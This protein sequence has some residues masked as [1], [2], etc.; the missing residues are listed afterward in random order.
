MSSVEHA[1]V[2]TSVLDEFCGR[3]HRELG[4]EV[5]DP[6]KAEMGRFLRS[7]D[8]DLEAAFALYRQHVEWRT[9][10]R[11]SEL[12]PE[13]MPTFFASGMSRVAGHDKAGHPILLMK[14]G[15]YQ[16]R[17][18]TPVRIPPALRRLCS[19]YTRLPLPLPPP[20][21]TG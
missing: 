1:A 18:T 5:T 13:R 17:I 20:S 12:T 21:R 16:P 15:R 7:R 2:D 8:N 3:A 9:R 4:V 11:V 6:A 19:S 14:A 10:M